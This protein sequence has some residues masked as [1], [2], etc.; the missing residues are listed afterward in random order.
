MDDLN[1][2]IA[3]TLVLAGMLSGAAVGLGFARDDFAG[4]YES[5]TRRLMRLG[6]ISFFG[7]AGVN[8]MFWLTVKLAGPF[9]W[10]TL[11]DAASVMLAAGGVLMP[12]VC[13]LSARWKPWRHAFPVPVICLIGGVVLLMIGGLSS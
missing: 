6:H 3:W 7:L 10:A 12:A 11:I 9:E 5:W 4:G 8:F 2:W 13:Y 1:L